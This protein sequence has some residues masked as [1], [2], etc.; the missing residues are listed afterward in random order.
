M[1]HAVR[2]LRAVADALLTIAA[3]VG[4]LGFALFVAVRLGAVQPLVVTSGSMSPTYETGDL[5]VSRPVDADAL[6]PGD[7]A[8]L[9]SADGRLI[10][11]RVTS[12]VPAERGT[13]PGTVAVEMQGDANDAADPR[14]YV[15]RRALVPVITVP[16][17]G[18]FVATVQRPGVA[19]PALVAVAAL[20]AIAF[21]PTGHPPPAVPKEQGDPSEPAAA[22]TADD[23]GP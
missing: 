22:R 19:V 23:A 1:G 11:H 10:T 7:V 4:V 2:S 17:V 8:S 9:L 21:V 18:P 13:S 6:Q 16:G 12:V 3:I 15:V 14:P 20:V 5:L